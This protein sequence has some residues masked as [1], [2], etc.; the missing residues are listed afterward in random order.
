MVLQTVAGH[1]IGEDAEDLK[2]WM[3]GC[4]AARW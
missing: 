4:A 2:A 1:R 3:S